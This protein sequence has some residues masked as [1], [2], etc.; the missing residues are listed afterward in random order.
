MVI[1]RAAVSA[2]GVLASCNDQ[3]GAGINAVHV[4]SPACDEFTSEIP[5]ATTR[6]EY[7]HAFGVADEIQQ[8]NVGDLRLKLVEPFPNDALPVRRVLLIPTRYF[9]VT[10]YLV[11]PCHPLT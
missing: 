3:F 6:V 10:Q 5:F 8:R 7:A 11:S 2:L 1:F 4:R 9:E